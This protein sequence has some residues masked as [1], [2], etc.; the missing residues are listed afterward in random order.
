MADEGFQM[1]S[2]GWTYPHE[3]IFQI[4][5]SHTG[6]L[7]CTHSGTSGAQSSL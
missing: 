7:G 5:V 6:F 4:R 1:T 3:A 2:K